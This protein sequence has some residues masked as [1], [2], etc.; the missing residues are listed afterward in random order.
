M[1]ALEPTLFSTRPSDWI[2]TLKRISDQFIV[3]L[4][5]GPGDDEDFAAAVRRFPDSSRTVI[6]AVDR[7]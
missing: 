4:W 6:T 1:L 3:E 5:N 7:N 2:L